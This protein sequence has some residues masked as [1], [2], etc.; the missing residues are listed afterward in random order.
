MVC[1][2]NLYFKE[3]TDVTCVCIC[4]YLVY[5]AF[6]S[7][8]LEDFTNHWNVYDWEEYVK[9]ATTWLKAVYVIIH[10]L[11]TS[12]VLFKIHEIWIGLF[13]PIITGWCVHNKVKIGVK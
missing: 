5:S 3:A 11:K 2:F 9:T 6:H 1:K 13:D 8:T 4:I 10:T 7:D 12:E